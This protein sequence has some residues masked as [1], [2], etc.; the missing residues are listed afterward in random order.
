MVICDFCFQEVNLIFD[1]VKFLFIFK[2][3]EFD[4]LLTLSEAVSLGTEGEQHMLSL[5]HEGK[6]WEGEF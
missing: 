5:N 3:S 2:E 1:I 6:E 4:P